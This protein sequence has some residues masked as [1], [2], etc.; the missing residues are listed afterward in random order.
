MTDYAL[1][2]A[3]IHSL[4]EGISYPVTV[5]SNASALLYEALPDLN[6]CGFYLR[7]GGT[8]YLGPFQGKIA[9]TLIP[10]GKGVCGTAARD[11]KAVCVADVHQFPGHIACDS[12]SNSEIVLPLRVHGE[13]WGVLDLDSPLFGRFLP[14]DEKGLADIA[15]CLSEIL[16][17]I[18]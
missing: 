17:K 3:Q 8:L 16:E 13:V 7:D 9:C 4:S 6:W 12:A 11:G 15:G 18:S 10:W 14:E 1:L 5:L 2:T